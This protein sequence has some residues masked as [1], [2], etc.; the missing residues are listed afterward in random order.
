MVLS[1]VEAK[2][3]IE[4]ELEKLYP[5][6][7]YRMTK[8]GLDIHS[9]ATHRIILIKEVGVDSRLCGYIGKAVMLGISR[10]EIESSLEF[11]MWVSSRAERAGLFGM[12]R[13][14]SSDFRDDLEYHGGCSVVFFVEYIGYVPY[15]EKGVMEFIR[16]FKESVEFRRIED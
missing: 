1:A 12:S 7:G 15:T 13:N 9:N 11:H 2:K 16:K 10:R 3:R 14:F 6:H 5:G 4:E 8:Q